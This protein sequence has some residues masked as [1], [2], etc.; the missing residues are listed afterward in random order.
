VREAADVTLGGQVAPDPHE[1]ALW[2][3][4]TKPHYYDVKG[5]PEQ[6]AQLNWRIAQAR[7]KLTASHKQ[8]GDAADDRLERDDKA[9][10][11]LYVKYEPLE[12]E[13]LDLL[14]SRVDRATG[15][16]LLQKAEKSA[17]GGLIGVGSIVLPVTAAATGPTLPARRPMTL[18]RSPELAR[19]TLEPA[20]APATAGANRGVLGPGP[21]AGGGAAQPSPVTS[22]LSTSPPRVAAAQ[23]Q[24]VA[25]T[26]SPL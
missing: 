5:T 12:R 16:A 22:L 26:P 25:G 1:S 11:N 8:Y 7:A 19:V 4:A 17:T 14:K 13:D 6:I 10:Y 9:A 24:G 3:Y 15:G 18:T 2:Q 23:Y 21:V 20:A